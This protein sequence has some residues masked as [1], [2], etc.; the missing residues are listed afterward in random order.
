MLFI[1]TAA[2]VVIFWHELGH[3]AVARWAGIGV[4]EFSVGVG[5]K[6]FGGRIGKT[7]YAFRLLPLGGYIDPVDWGDLEDV[8]K[9]EPVEAAMVKNKRVWLSNQ[10][11]YERIALFLAG[12]VFNLVAALVLFYLA[13]LPMNFDGSLWNILQA[14]WNT[15]AR[16]AVLGF[17]QGQNIHSLDHFSGMITGWHLGTSYFLRHMAILNMGL[18]LL[19][20]VP[21]LP[22]DGGQVIKE[23]VFQLHHGHLTGSA[24][25]QAQKRAMGIYTA[26][27]LAG[28]V[29]IIGLQCVAW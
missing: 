21:I 12:P 11:L 14:T 3:L 17:S 20:L 16:E 27:A 19:N 13:G 7:R 23:M 9:L 15:Q 10:P 24:R 2:I 5:W 1:L 26:L 29:I 8:P 6:V 22:L 28:L 4:Q 25:L 18:G